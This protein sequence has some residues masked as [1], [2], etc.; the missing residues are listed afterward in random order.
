MTADT[1]AALRKYIRPLAPIATALIPRGELRRTIRCVLFDIYGTLFVSA[2]GDI[3][4]A[5]QGSPNLAQIESLLANYGVH[6]APLDLL[7]EFQ[8]AIKARHGELRRSGVEFPEVKID[9]IWQRLLP[10]DDQRDIMRFAAEFE[11][12]T[13]PVYPMPHLARLL[14]A[15]RQQGLLMGIISN[16]QFY[17]PLLFK[18]FLKSDTNALGFSA[19]L[20]FYSYVFETAKPSKA[21][22]EMAAEKLAG[23]GIPPAAVLYIGNDMLNDIYPASRIGFQT[24]LF[25]GDQRSLRL[26][27]DDPRCRDLKPEL[28][29]TEL[30]QLIRHMHA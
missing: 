30:D 25:A 8:G 21:L 15:G 9:R 12:I 27:A 4:L 13:N 1:N 28:V 7:N 22:F 23:K 16:A 2:S 26:R 10:L 14:A 17:T 6:A 11:F 20:V 5:A 24:A 18:L 3:S 19:D 29:V